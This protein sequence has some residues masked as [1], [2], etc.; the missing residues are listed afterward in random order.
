PLLFIGLERL[1]PWLKRREEGAGGGGAAEDRE[2]MQAPLLPQHSHT[3]L[4]GFGRVGHLVADALQQK[5]QPFIVIE[6]HA[7]AVEVLNAKGTPAIYGNAAAPGMLDAA[8]IANARCLLVA[9]PD[10]LE[11]GQV[12][13]HALKLN[14]NL[15]VVARAHSAAEIEHL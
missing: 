5:K 15:H 10:A 7:D 3:V 2:D 1:K 8:N 12:I 6:D 4:I 9:I 11:A 14:P 13:E